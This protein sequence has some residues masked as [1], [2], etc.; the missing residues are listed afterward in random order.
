MFGLWVVCIIVTI[1]IIYV[2]SAT[3][4]TARICDCVFKSGDLIL[5]HS[6][7]TWNSTKMLSYFTHIGV[8]IALP[9]RAPRLLEINRNGVLL[10]TSDRPQTDVA[11]TDL[12]ERINKYHGAVFH[13]NLSANLPDNVVES[14]IDF[15]ERYAK[16][17]IKYASSL[18]MSSLNR[19]IGYRNF[20]ESNCGEFTMLCLIK[21]GLLPLSDMDT[22]RVHYLRYV[23]GLTT[24]QRGLTYGPPIRLI[25]TF[26]VIE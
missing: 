20:S 26:D 21:L 8:V 22:W 10:S 2:T 19:A 17:N 9:N 7:N 18:V 11:F 12:F 5:F 3:Y 15:V 23:C 1:A 14:L 6:Q 16:T 13:K 24:L 25:K 4:I